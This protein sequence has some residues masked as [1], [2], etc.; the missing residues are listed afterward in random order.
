MAPSSGPRAKTAWCRP[1]VAVP[2]AVQRMGVVV[3]AAGLPAL[4]LA[5]QA[6]KGSAEPE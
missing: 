5:S 4:A 6:E 3:L 1:K 2:G